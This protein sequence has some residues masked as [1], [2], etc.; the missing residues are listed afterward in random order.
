MNKT[1][2]NNLAN[3]YHYINGTITTILLTVL[4]VFRIRKNRIL[5][6]SYYGKGYGDNA[7][8]IIENLLQNKKK[9]QIYWAVKNKKSVMPNGIKTVKYNSIKYHYIL[10]TSHVWINNTRFECG[11][12]KRKKQYY[13]QTWHGGLPLIQIEEDIEDKLPRYYVAAAKNDSKMID[14]LIS[15]NSY[16]T[17][18]FKKN[19]WYQGKILECGSPRNDLIVKNDPAIAKKVKKAYKLNSSKKICLYAPTFRNDFNVF[20]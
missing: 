12:R 8:Y 5:V 1:I 6:V 17:D 11:V 10:A 2:R 15:T 20:K 14:L 3:V 19:F 9:Y 18:R 4:S 7:K 16:M 13:I